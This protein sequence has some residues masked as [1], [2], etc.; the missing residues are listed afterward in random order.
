[1]RRIQGYT[2]LPICEHTYNCGMPNNVEE[3]LGTVVAF[4]KSSSFYPTCEQQQQMNAF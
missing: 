3:V 1:M 2:Y 4:W